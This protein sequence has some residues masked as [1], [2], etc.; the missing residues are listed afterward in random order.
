MN[1]PESLEG[2]GKI[3]R[4]GG[5]HHQESPC[6]A[7]YQFV[8]RVGETQASRG[9]SSVTSL[10]SNLQRVLA[11]TDA[12][13]SCTPRCDQACSCGENSSGVSTVAPIIPGLTTKFQKSSTRPQ[14][15]D[16]TMR[17]SRSSSASVPPANCLVPAALRSFAGAPVPRSERYFGAS[18]AVIASKRGSPRSGS[19]SG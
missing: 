15:R 1:A 7:R 16:A 14:K 18:E 17:V 6:G 13:L 10:A 11:A 4:S 9:E 8:M 19:Q 3:S 12:V 2:A 5:D